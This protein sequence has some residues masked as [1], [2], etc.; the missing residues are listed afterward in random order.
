L[1]DGIR[2]GC[3]LANK[4]KVKAPISD[5]EARR[6]GDIIRDFLNKS[7]AVFPDEKQLC[8]INI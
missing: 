2:R 7:K 6:H 8:A 4:I 5:D 1:F 3:I